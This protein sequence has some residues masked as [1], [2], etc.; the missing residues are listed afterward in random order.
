MEDGLEA[1]AHRHHEHHEIPTSGSA[2]TGVAFSATLHCLT[3]CA[4]GEIAGMAIGTALGFSDFATIALAVALAFLFGY[5][6]TSLPLLRAGLA[7]SAVVPIALASDTLSIATMEI[8]DNAIMLL[9]PGAMDAGIGSL[10]FWGSLSVALV[11]AGAV[12]LPVNRWLIARGKGHVAVHNTGIHGGPPTRVVAAVAAVAAVFGTVVLTAE[13]INSEGGHGAGHEETAATGGAAADPVRGLA[14][15]ADGMTLA[16]G[17]TEFP[18][19]RLGRFEF[20]ILGADGEP[21]R[22]FEIEHE[23]RLH[24]IVVRRDMT[25]FQHLHPKLGADGTWHTPLRLRGA[26]SYRVFADF[27]HE[28]KAHTLGADLAV[29]GPADWK[30]LPAQ[31]DAAQTGD[32]YEV[33]MEGGRSPGREAELRFTVLLRG[34]A[35]AVEPYLGAGGHLVA[36]RQGDLAYLHVHPTGHGGTPEHTAGAAGPVG[37]TTA[38]PT[39]GRYRLFLQFK[40]AGRIHTAAFTRDLSEVS[41]GERQNGGHHG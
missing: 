7:F 23:Q 38:F 39:E 33:R 28:G 20:R 26:G 8:V 16:L 6:L 35:V 37:F 17:A 18:R 12:A 24:L 4:L 34:K 41:G 13:A 14:V 19:D 5:T 29:D 15:S 2:L 11:I 30:R 21:V 3:G 1:A 40:H 9:V 10:L 27:K 31:S 32:G 36:L 22:E 25:G